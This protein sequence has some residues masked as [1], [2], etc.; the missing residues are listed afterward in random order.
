[1]KWIKE[2]L[3]AFA[4]FLQEEIPCDG[5][6]GKNPEKRQKHQNAE[7]FFMVLSPW[8]GNLLTAVGLWFTPS[9][10]FAA[11]PTDKLRFSN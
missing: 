6:L 7:S 10:N 8:A 4:N 2:Q 3:P 1:M 11:M 9:R 5:D